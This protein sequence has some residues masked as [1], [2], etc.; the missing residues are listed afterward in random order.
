MSTFIVISMI[1]LISILAAI[2]Q[3]LQRIFD[4]L[5]WSISADVAK[6]LGL[7]PNSAQL[8]VYMLTMIDRIWP[9]AGRPWAK[10]VWPAVVQ[11]AKIGK[12]KKQDP[13]IVKPKKGNH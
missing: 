8:Q 7:K 3:M 5:A 10:K 12:K 4:L 1:F 2:Y 11:G 9:G 13:V 6:D